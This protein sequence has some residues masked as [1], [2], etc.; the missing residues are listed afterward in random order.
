VA[1]TKIEWAD[2][3]K[4][5]SRIKTREGYILVY[6]PT[7]P[8]AKSKGHMYEHRYLMEK[9]LGRYLETTESVHHKNGDKSDNR[10]SNLELVAQAIHARQHYEN[11]PRA[12]KER[13]IAKIVSANKMRAHPREQILCAC[14][15]G[16]SFTNRDSKGRLRKY[17]HGHGNRGKHWSWHGKV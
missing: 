5:T 12:D 14:G 15:C 13:T 2:H 8:H 17:V 4:G 6:C 10:M 11:Q 9:H 3:R 1:R 7:H 16:T